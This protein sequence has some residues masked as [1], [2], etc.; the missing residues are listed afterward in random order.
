M[1]PDEDENAHYGRNR[2]IRIARISAQ[3]KYVRP[4]YSA[5]RSVLWGSTCIPQTVYRIGHR[6]EDKSG[7][8]SVEEVIR[9][10]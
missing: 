7:E 4:S 10:F 2:Y 9:K 8:N 5:V 1:Q 3:K 6:A